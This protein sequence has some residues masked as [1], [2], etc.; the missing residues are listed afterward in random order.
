[1]RYGLE[2]RYGVDLPYNAYCDTLHLS[3]QPHLTYCTRVIWV[4]LQWDRG[5]AL[6]YWRAGKISFEQWLK[7]KENVDRPF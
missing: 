3:I 6:A 5:D 7:R 4:D 1:M 2:V